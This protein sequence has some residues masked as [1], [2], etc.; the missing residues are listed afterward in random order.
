M[1][2]GNLYSNKGIR[3]G[4]TWYEAV[5]TYSCIIHTLSWWALSTLGDEWST[6]LLGDIQVLE[7]GCWCLSKVCYALS[8]L[9]HS[10]EIIFLTF[11]SRSLFLI[12]IFHD[13][14]W[15]GWIFIKFVLT[16]PKISN[17][18]PYLR[19]WYLLVSY[20]HSLQYII[21]ST[22]FWMLYYFSY[23]IFFFYWF[24]GMKVNCKN[25]VNLWISFSIHVPLK[26]SMGVHLLT[27]SWEISGTNQFFGL[28]VWATLSPWGKKIWC[29]YFLSKNM[30]SLYFSSYCSS[31]FIAETNLTNWI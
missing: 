22:S 7:I 9:S 26:L 20:L 13:W 3:I 2:L 23:S 25:S 11:M 27:I 8:I 4:E 30:L 10:A 29:K 14:S 16:L 19:N 17:H 21:A 6:G 1:W 18:D 5:E 31:T 12:L 24:L 15:T 28:V